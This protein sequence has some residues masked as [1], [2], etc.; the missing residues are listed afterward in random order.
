MQELEQ[1]YEATRLN[2]TD[3][4]Q[5]NGS[6]YQYLYSDPYAQSNYPRFVFRPLPGQRCKADLVVNKNNIRKVWL[7]PGYQARQVS[8]V[9]EKAVQMS[10]F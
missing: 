3:V 1:V 8:E 4:Y 7:V 2:Q 5:I 10:L 9:S 6:L